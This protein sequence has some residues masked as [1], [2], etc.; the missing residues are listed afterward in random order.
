M[1]KLSFSTFRKEQTYHFETRFIKRN[2]WS[3]IIIQINILI[4]RV[5]FNLGINHF[6]L[7]FRK[8]ET[9]K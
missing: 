1:K 9:G 8:G 6:L 2:T 7:F 4:L 3:K 5:K